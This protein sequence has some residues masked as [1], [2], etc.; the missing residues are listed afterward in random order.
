MDCDSIQEEGEIIDFDDEEENKQVQEEEETAAYNPIIRP[1]TQ[2]SVQFQQ[3][4]HSDT[5]SN[6]SDD[7]EENIKKIPPSQKPKFSNKSGNLWAQM[8]QEEDLMDNLKSCEVNR[9]RKYEVD[10]GVETYKLED[11]VNYKKQR[12]DTASSADEPSIIRKYAKGKIKSLHKPKKLEDLVVADNY[13]DE[14]YGIEVAKKLSEQNVDL[15]H[16][17]VATIGREKVNDLYEKTRNIE[18]KGGM[19]IVNK[20][21]RRTS[22][23]IFLFLL[24]TSNVIDEAQKKEIFDDGKEE[25][26]KELST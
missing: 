6:E 20:S 18:R 24:K 11:P 26:T 9:K 14:D 15:I 10:R 2:R 22:G 8:L 12:T 21:R 5:S 17:V 16:K 23:G 19:L 4:Q 3:L 25:A 1:E 7:E 13:N